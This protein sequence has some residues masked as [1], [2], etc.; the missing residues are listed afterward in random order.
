MDA[1]STTSAV[2]RPGRGRVFDSIVDAIGNTPIVRLRQFAQ[3][4]DRGV[5]DRV[6]DRVENPAPAGTVHCISG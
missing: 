6:D 4:D 2:Q 3:A 5:A 1:P